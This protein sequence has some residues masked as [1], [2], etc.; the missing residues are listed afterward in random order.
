MKRPTPIIS[1]DDTL[2][3]RISLARDARKLTIGE[4]AGLAGVL[5]EIWRAWEND[6]AEPEEAQFIAVAD[7][8]QVS[9][10]WL[11][12]GRGPGP[13]WASGSTTKLDCTTA[14]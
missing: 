1:G 8:L 12:I 14:T 2:G 10:R 4:A 13:D 9:L 6:R 5:E 11:L 7:A 3:G